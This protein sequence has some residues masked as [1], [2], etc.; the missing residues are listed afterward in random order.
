[1]RLSPQAQSIVDS[2]RT[3]GPATDNQLANRLEI[4]SPSV[5][6]ARREA[7]VKGAVRMSFDGGDFGPLTWEA[8]Q[9]QEAASY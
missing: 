8:H 2:L 4:P 5:R 3:V 6:R 7:E 1:M 9:P